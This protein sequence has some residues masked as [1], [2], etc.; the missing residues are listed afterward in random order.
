MAMDRKEENTDI[1]LFSMII[2]ETLASFATAE[3]GDFCIGLDAMTDV[4]RI[5]KGC[6][7]WRGWALCVCIRGTA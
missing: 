1:I 4:V 6:H 2:G 7:S 5:V 3:L